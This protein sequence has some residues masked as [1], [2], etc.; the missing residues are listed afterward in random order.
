MATRSMLNAHLTRD[1]RAFHSDRVTAHQP[2]L[3]GVPPALLP[4][5]LAPFPDCTDA[6]AA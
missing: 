6:I 2:A 4:Q 5:D 1:M 3:H